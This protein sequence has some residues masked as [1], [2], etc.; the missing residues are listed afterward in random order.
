MTHAQCS[1][2]KWRK[3]NLNDPRC[4]S[5][6]CGSLG[7]LEGLPRR[8]GVAINGSPPIGVLATSFPLAAESLRLALAGV[9]MPASLEDRP[10][11]NGVTVVGRASS[12]AAVATSS[13]EWIATEEGRLRVE[14]EGVFGRLVASELST[15]ATTGCIAS[16][17]TAS[18]LMASCSTAS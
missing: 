11:L 8:E 10:R 4:A 15:E 14:R 5:S 12:A 17:M 3:T 6:I 1:E 7:C 9:A 16:M 2:F 18:S 13:S